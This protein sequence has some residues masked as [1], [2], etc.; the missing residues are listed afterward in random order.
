LK[1][2]VEIKVQNV[3]ASA[4][5]GHSI[6]LNSVIRAYP[7]IEYAPRN[8]PGLP[9]RLK[10]PKTCTLIFRSGSMICTGARS[11]RD[12]ERAIRKVVR[13]LKRG[14]LIIRMSRPEIV[15]QNI[16]AS[17][18]VKGARIDIER[19]YNLLWDKARIIPDQFPGLEYHMEDPRV[20]FLI[21]RSG[22]LVCTGAKR[23]E[24]V[25]TATEKLVATLEET[26]VLFEVS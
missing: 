3:V 23:E 10:K 1:F 20:T 24:D 4:K 21:F 12:A 18:G 17:G 15:I 13:K 16:I 25:Y 14:G 7:E 9:F 19:L 5:L 22:N 11:A 2:E 26:G 8:F 6:D